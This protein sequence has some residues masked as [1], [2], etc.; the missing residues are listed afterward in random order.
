MF[1]T[2]DNLHL[3]IIRVL[4]MQGQYWL[5]EKLVITN[6]LLKWIHLL[7]FINHWYKVPRYKDVCSIVP[8]Q[9]GSSDQY[10]VHSFSQD[11]NNKKQQPPIHFFQPGQQQ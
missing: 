3:E 8:D 6:I 5:T 7:I 11:N 2:T 9:S 1:E 4:K 10:Y